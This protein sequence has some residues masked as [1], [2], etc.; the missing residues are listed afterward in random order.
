MLLLDPSIPEKNDFKPPDVGPTTSAH[1]CTVRW[2]GW[3]STGKW[4]KE[5]VPTSEGGWC[6]WSFDAVEQRDVS[7]RHRWLR[8]NAPDGE[9]GR[10]FKLLYLGYIALASS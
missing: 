10:A 7:S 5:Y 2:F 4:D 9:S 1:D 6:H 8:P 3:P